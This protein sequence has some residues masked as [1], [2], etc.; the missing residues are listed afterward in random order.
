[1]TKIQSYNSSTSWQQGGGQQGSGSGQCDLQTS[2]HVS[3]PDPKCRIHPWLETSAL[4]KIW[5]LHSEDA[6]DWDLLGCY[7][8]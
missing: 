6:E 3:F 4:R 7:A 1:M 5:D 8:E 2:N